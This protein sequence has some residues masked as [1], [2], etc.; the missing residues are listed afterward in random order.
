MTDN[1]YVLIERD[2]ESDRPLI[3]V[4]GLNA[5]DLLVAASF[6]CEMI[7]QRSGLRRQQTRRTW[8]P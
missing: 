3:T 8:R 1:P 5:D 4:E 2:M 7:L 6:L